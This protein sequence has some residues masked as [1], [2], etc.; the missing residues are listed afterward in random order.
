MA[1]GW[2]PR[3]LKAS[4]KAYVGML[5]KEL[6]REDLNK[7]QVNRKLREGPLRQRSRSSVEMRMQNI[8]AVLAEAGLP[9]VSGYKP[10]R[11]VGA[12]IFAQI[13]AYLVAEGIDELESRQPTSDREELEGRVTQLR[14]E[15][16]AGEPPKGN[17][18]PEATTQT[19]REYVR[20]PQVKAH[21]LNSASGR[22]EACKQDAPF[23]TVDGFP[24][25]E[26]HH[27]KELSQGGSD[28][29]PNLVALC[30]NC[31]RRLHYGEDRE[32][33]KQGIYRAMPRL[34]QE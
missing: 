26:V 28:T 4:V 33:Y 18:K 2:A 24:F 3:E 21:V 16:R 9:F 29:V 11:N 5:E 17:M 15:L 7:A 14:A 23:K 25:L 13:R 22:C 27:L 1:Q 8:S 30:P 6:L 10:L 19:R 34:L 12:A 31:H 32:S 20:D